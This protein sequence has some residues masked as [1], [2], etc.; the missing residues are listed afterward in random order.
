MR[1]TDPRGPSGTIS[2]VTFWLQKRLSRRRAIILRLLQD[3]GALT[4]VELA[5]RSL[6]SLSWGRICNDLADLEEDGFVTHDEVEG[7]RRRY[8]ISRDGRLELAQLD[9][10]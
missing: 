4:G 8:Q 2:I 1:A 6:G 10:S 7:P 9:A 3:K 5:R